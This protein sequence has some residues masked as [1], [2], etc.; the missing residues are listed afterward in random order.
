MRFVIIEDEE[1]AARRLEKLVAEIK[2]TYIMLA[3][4]DSVEA[5]CRALPSLN[6]DLVFMDIQLADGN[7]FEIFEQISVN[8]P[9]IFTT[10]CDE[11][12]LKAFKQNSIDYLLKPLD[13]EEL[14]KALRKF[15]S[16]FSQQ[17][18]LELDAII[19]AFSKKGKERFL[20]KIGEHLRFVETKNIQLVY[21]KFKATY[22]LD[23]DGKS[24]VL[25][26]S[27]DKVEEMLDTTVFFRVSR[28]FIVNLHFIKDIIAYSNSRLQI[29]INS[30]EEEEVVVA[31]ERVQ[32]FKQWLDR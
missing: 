30:Y 22:V 28:K 8:A 13:P 11:Y 23:K 14:E 31:R 5:T 32:N 16:N 9:V 12:A 7:S 27:M 6:Y 21:S 29:I 3:T 18:P 20:V 24:F 2:P 17:K 4:F 10:A 19:N 26:H 25:D 15:E 1:I